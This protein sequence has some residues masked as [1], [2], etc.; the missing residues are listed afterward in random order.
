MDSNTPRECDLQL[1][2]IRNLIAERE[3]NIAQANRELQTGDDWLSDH[4][5]ED[6]RIAKEVEELIKGFNNEQ[7]PTTHS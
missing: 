7:S 1:L 6:C 3:M 2:Q 5:S 4:F